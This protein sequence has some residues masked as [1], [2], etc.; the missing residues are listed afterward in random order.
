[1][2]SLECQAYIFGSIF[3]LSNKLQIL[4]DRLDERL[5]VKQWLFLAGVLRCESEAPTLSEIAACIG[6]S[7][8]N[9]KKMALILEKRGFVSMNKDDR[10]SRM[11]RVSL[12]E[13]CKEH[14]K[15]REGIELKFI[16]EVFR[17][18][19]EEELSALSDAIGKLDHNIHI[20]EQNYGNE[21]E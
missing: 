11:V 21:E 13:A 8:Q 18:F 16:S 5:T 1:M 4:G 7:R 19:N 14:L 2:N 12:S 3:T 9:V 20:M 6:S 10:D 15:Q 17:D